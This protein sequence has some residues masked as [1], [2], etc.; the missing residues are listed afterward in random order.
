MIEEELRNKGIPEENR[1]YNEEVSV[2]K[3]KLSSAIR[4]DTALVVSFNV[5]DVQNIRSVA[6][7]LNNKRQEF[8]I[9]GSRCSIIFKD[10]P[11]LSDPSRND[12]VLKLDEVEFVCIPEYLTD[13]K[14]PASITISDVSIQKV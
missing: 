4:F 6:V 2:L 10:Y 12:S 11:N 3:F 13:A 8:V 9:K 5:K 1:R 14:K 7:V